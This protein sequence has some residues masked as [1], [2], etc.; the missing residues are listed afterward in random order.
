MSKMISRMSGQAEASAK[1]RL[2]VSPT[3]EFYG[4]YFL[5]DN[6]NP[7]PG[8]MS[9]PKDAIEVDKRPPS[10]RHIWNS[11][12]KQWR[13]PELTDR[14]KQKAEA[15][16]AKAALKQSALKKIEALGISA[17]ELRALMSR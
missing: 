13:L 3:G 4:E 12:T 11:A 2:F 1:G 7:L 6:G 8:G 15:K 16:E 17:D 14:E 5:D 10:H 9:P